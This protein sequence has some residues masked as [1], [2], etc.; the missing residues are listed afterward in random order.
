MRINAYHQDPWGISVGGCW[1]G[2][3]TGLGFVLSDVGKG[4]KKAG[5]GSGLDAI[6]KQG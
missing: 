6:R 2:L 4:S 3:V 1:G 5:L